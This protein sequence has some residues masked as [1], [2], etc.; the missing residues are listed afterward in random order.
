MK[1][2]SL[3]KELRTF[4]KSIKMGNSESTEDH[5]PNKINTDPLVMG[6]KNLIGSMYIIG[7]EEGSSVHYSVV[8]D[9]SGETNSSE[10]I[11]K[12][13]SIY[14]REEMGVELNPYKQRFPRDKLV[15]CDSVGTLPTPPGF[16]EHSY[17]S[18]QAALWCT[19]LDMITGEFY[20]KFKKVW[21]YVDNPSHMFSAS[22]IIFLLEEAKNNYQMFQPID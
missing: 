1:V 12:E 11:G 14:Y 17:F 4:K 7:R 8:V 9:T 18:A 3:Y 2:K 15:K 13:L 16:Y 21:S 10:I 19:K 6:D 22:L 20:E 5:V